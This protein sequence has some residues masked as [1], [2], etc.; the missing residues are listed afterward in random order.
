[1]LL[2][3]KVPL[4]YTLE[5]CLEYTRSDRY[6]GMMLVWRS[7]NFLSLDYSKYYQWLVTIEKGGVCCGFGPP[8]RCTVSASSVV[9]YSRRGRPSHKHMAY[10]VVIRSETSTVKEHRERLVARQGFAETRKI[11]YA[12]VYAQGIP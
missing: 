6:A 3:L 10:Q 1:M 5:D 12:C 2:N 7:Y 9:G 8:T 4:K 11:L